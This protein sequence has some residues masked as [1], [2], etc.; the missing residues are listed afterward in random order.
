MRK[1]G[2]VL[3]AAVVVLA[4][5][6]SAA[7][8]ESMLR[9]EPQAPGAMSDA[10]KKMLRRTPVVEAVEQVRDS[11]V[12]ISVTQVVRRSPFPEWFDLPREFGTSQQVQSAG[13]GFVLHASGYIV[14]NAHVVEGARQPKV[15][16]GDGQAL[17]ARVLAVDAEHDLAVLKV[18]A[19]RPLRAA[20]LGTSSDLMIG[21]TA[22]AIGN[23]FGF[24]HTVTA[25]VVSA[26]DRTLKFQDARS[27]QGIKEYKGLIQTDAAINPGNSGGPLL[28]ILGEVIGINT[29]I[30]GDAQNIGFAIAVDQLRKFL[31]GI[32]DVERINRVTLGVHF[33]GVGPAKVTE[34]DENS[35]A[36]AAGM[37]VGDLIIAVDGRPIAQDI[38]FFVEMME[39]KAGEDVTLTVMRGS[40]RQSFVVQ[41]GAQPDGNVQAWRKLGMRLRNLSAEQAG[42]LGLSSSG[43]LMIYEVH[44][45]G[46]AYEAGIEPGDILLQVGRTPAKDLG[47]VADALDSVKPGQIVNVMIVRVQRSRLGTR[48]GQFNVA[49]KAK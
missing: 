36:A 29:A 39:K 48:M 15:T 16:F 6:G 7:A 5:T 21:E 3:M 33:E 9:R 44:E 18:N 31:P 11:V 41:L 46:S 34:V 8:Q 28:N 17:D 47:A 32:M 24:Q 19:D 27:P 2:K 43:G 30:R 49:L 45:V 37:R 12:N 4:G 20:V 40:R 14:T 42:R 22:I 35:P 1:F 38:D 10:R 13:S 23:P 26:A 25:G